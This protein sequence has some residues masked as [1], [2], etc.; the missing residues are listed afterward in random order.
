ML[1]YEGYISN[2]L[3]VNTKKLLCGTFELLPLHLMEK[4]INHVGL[5][6]F[7]NLKERE[8]L[9]GKLLYKEESS[10][11]RKCAHNYRSEVGMLRYPQRSNR[12]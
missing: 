11:G 4:I 10:I 12:T 1:T 7:V 8:M 6:V 2:Y 5:T 9:T 3:G